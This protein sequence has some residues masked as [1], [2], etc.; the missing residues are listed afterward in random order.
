MS[1]QRIGNRITRAVDG[2]PVTPV[3]A[4][5]ILVASTVNDGNAALSGA[6]TL[7]F[8][9][10]SDGTSDAKGYIGVQ[11][12]FVCQILAGGAITAGAL[13]VANGSGQAVVVTPLASLGALTQIIGVALHSAASGAL[14]DVQINPQI[15]LS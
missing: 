5:L 13:I 7:G 9:G 1:V 3:G 2:A 15:T 10:V 11:T 12:D 8:L 6:K 4:N 14:V